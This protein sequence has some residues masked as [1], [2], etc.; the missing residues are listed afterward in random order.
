MVRHEKFGTGV[1]IDAIGDKNRAKLKINFGQNGIKE[2]DTTFAK[3]KLEKI[4]LWKI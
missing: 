3:A 1:I 4:W 2:L